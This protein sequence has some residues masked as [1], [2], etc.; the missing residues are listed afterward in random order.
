MTLPLLLGLWATFLFSSP[1][2]AWSCVPVGNNFDSQILRIMPLGA[3]IVYGYDS[4]DGNGFRQELRLKLLANGANVNIIGSQ[5]GGTMP[6]NFV[7]AVSGYRI[8]EISGLADNSIPEQ[9]NLVI[10]HAGTNDIVQDYQPG[11]A[12]QRLGALI[13]K[14]LAKIPGTV[15]LVSTLIPNLNPAVNTGI[16]TLNT[17]IKQLVADRAGAGKHVHLADMSSILL[18]DLNTVDL[19][20]PTDSTSPVLRIK[21]D[22]Y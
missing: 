9:P 13:D 18:S 7:E 15:V 4:S 1:V 12:D 3:S 20:H 17:K 21:V 22:K 6:D 8:D 11:T 16:Q 10:V 19:T 5:K 14:L 2:D